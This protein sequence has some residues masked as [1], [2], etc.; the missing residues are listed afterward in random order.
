VIKNKI[1]VYTAI[2]GGYDK[3]NEPKFI[4]EGCDYICFTD[5]ENLK[6][7]IWKVIKINSTSCN[8]IRTA[9]KYKI[10]PHKYL[11]EY[12]YSI[13]VDGSMN[14][15]GDISDLVKNKMGHS[16]MIY[17]KHPWRNCIY[18]EVKACIKLNKDNPEVI[19]NQIRRYQIDG[20][21]RK[22]GL[23]ASGII[24]R[25]H[26]E[27]EVIDLME[28]W[29]KEVSQFSIRDQ[30][31]F[32]YVAWKKKSKYKLINKYINNNEYIKNNKHL[33]TYEKNKSK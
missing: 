33:K 4:S 32:N 9:R 30:L 23:I 27:K 14:I 8:N 31:S 13:W 1:V 24:V 25:K 16:N 29:W 10:L 22:Q 17:F 5:N 6:S 26:N 28:A 7:D 19:K 15:I 20:F 3:L 21:K 18:D 11:S 2:I 12:E